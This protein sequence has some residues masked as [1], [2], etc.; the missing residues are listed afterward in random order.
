ML[1]DVSLL[2]SLVIVLILFPYQGRELYRHYDRESGASEY[3]PAKD[4]VEN[5]LGAAED[6]LGGLAL[7]P[8]D[9]DGYDNI[10]AIARKLFA[11]GERER[12][13]ETLTRMDQLMDS[14]WASRKKDLAWSNVCSDKLEDCGPAYPLSAQLK[15]MIASMPQ[16]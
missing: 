9:A 12:A 16:Q 11:K 7:C 8:E 1:L 10:V 13:K 4:T 15:Q 5:L 2:P 3:D 14:K 6:C